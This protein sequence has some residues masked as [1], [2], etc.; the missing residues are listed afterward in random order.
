MS[1]LGGAFIP[2]NALPEAIRGISRFTLNYWGNESLRALSLGG[3]W[4]Q[5]GAHLPA[6]GAMAFVFTAVG[7]VL[8]RRGY[9]GLG[10]LAQIT[11]Q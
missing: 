11:H 5:L 3:G 1:L 9:A 2:P 4:E 7:V 10:G 8:L 6:L